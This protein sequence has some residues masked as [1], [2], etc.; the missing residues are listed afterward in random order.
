MNVLG[1]VTHFILEKD[2]LW[3][4]FVFFN[5]SLSIVWTCNLPVKDAREPIVCDE[6]V[7]LVRVTHCIE[8]VVEVCDDEHDDEVGDYFKLRLTVY[9]S[10]VNVGTLDDEAD[11]EL[12]ESCGEG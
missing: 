5:L 11:R 3:L 2:A 10:D 6:L 8:V 7:D 12:Q 9:K 4:K 1:P